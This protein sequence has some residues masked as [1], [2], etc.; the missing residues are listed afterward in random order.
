MKKL[1]ILTSILALAACGGGS[2]GGIG[3]S[4]G[5][6]TSDPINN[7]PTSYD[8]I[9]ITPSTDS[10]SGLSMI[11]NYN[12]ERS[13]I[14]KKA[15]TTALEI[16]NEYT[17]ITYSN[18][19]TA[20]SAARARAA[21]KTNSYTISQQ[22]IDNAFKTMYAILVEHKYENYTLHQLLVS[23]ALIYNKTEILELLGQGDST[24]DIK[25][26]NFVDNL[27][28]NTD[29]TC[30]AEDMHQEY[31]ISPISKLK[32]AKFY[33]NSGDNN[34]FKYVIDESTGNIT[35]IQEEQ[36]GITYTV[37]E[38]GVFERNID[39]KRYSFE[40]TGTGNQHI[41]VEL[42]YNTA[43][44]PSG[45]NAIREALKNKVVQKIGSQGAGL[46][47][48]N[49][50]IDNAPIIAVGA[51]CTNQ[52][53][54]IEWGIANY[55]EK[56]I[57]TSGGDA[58]LGL[59]YSDFGLIHNEMEFHKGDSELAGY[60]KDYTHK[61]YGGFIGGDDTKKATP[62]SGMEFKGNAYVGLTRK[63]SKEQQME[64]PDKIASYPKTTSYKGT[65]TLKVSDA[66]N[67]NLKQELVADFSNNGW[68]KVKVE[69]ML[70]NNNIK[71]NNIISFDAKASLSAESWF[72]L[73]IKVGIFLLYSFT[74]NSSKSSTASAEG[75]ALS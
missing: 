31:G 2:G 9:I 73:I 40:H 52:N 14:V 20:R 34:Y 65:A 12:K 61:E 28:N 4:V 23:L 13:S 53:G 56:K 49:S 58:D 68:Y 55:K 19:L 39:G 45:D 35:N 38:K 50:W 62:K 54:C 17:G 51:Q 30:K 15:I 74:R 24:L 71:D 10:N 27:K 21:A 25:I 57:I 48:I 64:N 60:D 7:T 43:D 3:A 66:G 16:E 32:E 67:N 22:D 46:D 37:N 42:E 75:T 70:L 1:A 69:D 8:N 11:N 18:V 5:Y 41:S 63:L 47:T 44:I 72:P 6:N 26:N 59:T 36:D 29:V 33:T